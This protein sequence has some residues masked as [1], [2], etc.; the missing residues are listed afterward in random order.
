MSKREEELQLLI[1]IDELEEEKKSFL[2]N[3]Y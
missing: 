2:E 3:N 1:K